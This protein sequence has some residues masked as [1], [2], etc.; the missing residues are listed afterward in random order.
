MPYKPRRHQLEGQLTY[1][2]MN[3]ATRR[4]EIF[5]ED[6]DYEKFKSILGRYI[7]KEGLLIYHYCLMPNHYHLQ[8]EIEDVERMSSVMAGIDRS[9]THYYHKKYGTSGYL[10]QGRFKSKPIQK[11]EYLLSCARYIENN[12]VRAKLVEKAESYSYSSA[13]HYVLGEEDAIITENPLYEE[14]GVI[15]EERR[16]N[17]SVFL[18]DL[19]GSQEESKKYGFCDF[20][21]PHG[22]EKFAARLCSKK[23]RLYPRRKGRVR[24]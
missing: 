18:S 2:L 22:D 3:R 5:H 14:F 10:W 20:K 15:V 12:P 7:L 8:A 19:K 9:Y 17:Y 13:K 1:H 6:E 23:G 24:N 21:K 11:N 16:Y 4:Y